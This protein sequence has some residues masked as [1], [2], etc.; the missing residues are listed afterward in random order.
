MFFDLQPVLLKPVAGHRNRSDKKHQCK[1]AECFLHGVVF[2][3]K[4]PV[5]SV[6]KLKKPP[7]LQL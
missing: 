2:L 3:Q 6:G 5:N 7:K 1:Q 4:H